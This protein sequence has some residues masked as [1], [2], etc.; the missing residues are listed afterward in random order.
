VLSGADGSEIDAI[1]G[2]EPAGHQFFDIDAAGDV[3]GDGMPDLLTSSPP[4]ISIFTSG[5]ADA[6]LYSLATGAPVL[7]LDS[8]PVAAGHGRSLAALGEVDG[9]GVG[10]YAVG[11]ND[12]VAV[13]S[14]AD[15]EMLHVVGNPDP[16]VYVGVIADTLAPLGDLDGDGVP[17]FAMGT[18]F[19]DNCELSPINCGGR[20]AAFSTAT[21]EVLWAVD[22]TDFSGRLGSSLAATEDLDG[23]G[24]RDLYA[25]DP[26]FGANAGRV[27]LLSGADGAILDVLDDDALAPI[28]QGARNVTSAGLFDAGA[29]GDVAIGAFGLEKGGGM[30][31]WASA[32]GGLFGFEDLG[33]AKAGSNG[34]EPSLVGFGDLSP[35]GLVTLR[36]RDALPGATGVWFLGLEVGNLPFKQG[37]LVPSPSPVLFSIPIVTD[38]EGSF[39][40]TA[41]N[42]DSVFA[43]VEL[44]H[45]MWFVDA[46]V[47]AQASATNG[48]REVF[49][50]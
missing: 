34:L 1:F 32:Q 8:E 17:D 35:G 6:R 47:P 19:V 20:V 14:G 39:A 42:P 16:S 28:Q 45:Q 50:D 10:D 44:V 2:D 4:S 43:G 7:V 29:S 23:D 46:G 18:V 25:A 5:T 30:Q 31:V 22:G 15:G 24:V 38:G 13:F 9:D 21:G 3:T 49:A 37:T 12:R 33:A 40:I 48:L 36:A 41:P 11:A 27:L 26:F